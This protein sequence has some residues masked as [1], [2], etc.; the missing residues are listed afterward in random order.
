MNTNPPL[1]SII[2]V[3]YNVENSIEETVLNVVAQ[4]Y[5]NYEHIIIDGGSKDGTLAVLK[6]HQEK[7]SYWVSE[8]DK[9]IYDAMNKGILQAKGDYVYFLNVGD[10][11]YQNT[12][13]EDLIPLIEKGDDVVY[14]NTC[15]SQLGLEIIEYP[16]SI[17][18]D[19]KKM[20]YCHQSVF[21]KRVLLLDCLFDLR[22]KIAA[23]YKQYFELMRKG[24]RFKY[25]DQTISKYDMGGFSFQN[26]LC[27]LK[28]K[29]EI[30]L[31][32]R[33]TILDQLKIHSFF[34]RSHLA[35][36]KAMLSTFKKKLS[37][38]NEY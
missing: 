26:P 3:S 10:V 14:G 30:A 35:Y 29:K 32:Y 4:T 9:G 15:L 12:T 8:P 19:W 33:T 23:D 25:I 31:M 20:P 16:T 38:Y 2:T 18:I 37:F 7:F 11:F 36:R 17:R 5:H 24:V 13:L 34:L 22:F 1:I 21:I 28:E 27:L 6:K